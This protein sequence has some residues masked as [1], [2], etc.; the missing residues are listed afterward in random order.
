MEGTG[1][2]RVI[3]KVQ[4]RKARC[5]NSHSEAD[6]DARNNDGLRADFGLRRDGRPEESK[7]REHA[8]A[9]RKQR[10]AGGPRR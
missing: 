8:S 4:K 2:G 7:R 10:D 5:H 1:E 9:G 3:Y 6:Q